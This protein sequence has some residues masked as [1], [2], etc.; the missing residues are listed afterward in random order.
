M[1]RMSGVL[2]ASDAASAASI[3]EIQ[4]GVQAASIVLHPTVA[5]LTTA[6]L[7]SLLGL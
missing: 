4:S 3:A 7:V 6:R 2:D 1:C 5:T